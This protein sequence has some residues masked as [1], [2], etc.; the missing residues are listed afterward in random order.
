MK[1]EHKSCGSKEKVW[2]PHISRE[3][4]YGLKSHPYC[5]HCGAV[6]NISD[7]MPMKIGHYINI[8]SKIRR[9]FRIS[10]AQVRLI[11][12]ELSSKEGFEDPYWSTGF[13]QEKMFL[14]SLKRY[15]NLQENTI[16]PLL[17]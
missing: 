6:K 15:C 16:K 12:N 8:L 4:V 7:D 11:I 13:A 9:S 14:A 10:D 1:C 17:S 5:I 2:L 3:E